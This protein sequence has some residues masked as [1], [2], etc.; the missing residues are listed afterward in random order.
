VCV[1][2]SPPSLKQSN[3][4]VI[5]AVEILMKNREYHTKDCLINEQQRLQ[6]TCHIPYNIYYLREIK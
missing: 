2:A 4:A 1:P 3:P 6:E 5:V